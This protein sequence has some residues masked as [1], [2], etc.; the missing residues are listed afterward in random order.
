MQIA[1][2]LY[3][4]SHSKKDLK[5]D[6]QSD[7]VTSF[8][9]SDVDTE[10]Q[11]SENEEIQSLITKIEHTNHR[12]FEYHIINLSEKNLAN[13]VNKIFSNDEKNRMREYWIEMEPSAEERQNTARHSKWVQVI[14]PLIDKY[15]SAIEIN[16]ESIFD[17][18]AQPPSMK[19]I[20]DSPFDGEFDFKKHYELFVFLF[21]S[22]FNILRDANTL[23]LAYRESFVNPIIPKAFEDMSDKIRFQIGEI[24][25]N[26]RKK[27][28]NQTKAQESRVSLG[29]KHDGILKLYVNACEIEIGF[30]E[31]VGNAMNVDLAGCCGDMEKLFK[32]LQLLNILALKNL[33]SKAHSL[34]TFIVMQI[35]IF[36]QRQ[37]HLERN[38]TEEQLLNIQSFGVLVYQLETTIYSMHRIKGGLH[39]VDIVTNFTI[40]D[41]KDQVYVIDEV[42]EKVY[43]FKSRVMDYYLKLQ[44]ISRKVQKYSPTNEKLLEASPSKRK[45]ARK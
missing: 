6:N 22:P 36:Y 3:L 12:L 21:S 35:S 10:N 20:F 9:D 40:P 5:R 26:L 39:I 16:P 45:S 38:A 13:P 8:D 32:G 25:S 18:D 44:D 33:C 42:I 14:K 29:S 1:I 28:R 4:S 43:F 34:F 2:C 31:V 37:H 30:L 17:D 41:N 7:D 19:V 27:H 11:L 23:E 15:A 24:E